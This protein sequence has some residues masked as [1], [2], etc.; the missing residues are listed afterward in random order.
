MDVRLRRP[1]GPVGVSELDVVVARDMSVVTVAVV[2]LASQGWTTARPEG[3]SSNHKVTLTHELRDVSSALAYNGETSGSARGN[4]EPS[5]VCKNRDLSMCHRRAQRGCDGPTV[6]RC[7]TLIK[8]N[9]TQTTHG[10]ID[11]TV[12][13][14]ILRMTVSTSPPVRFR[15]KLTN[16]DSMTVSHR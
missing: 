1:P 7:T 8:T 4:N 9:T 12:M 3:Q 14:M 16:T 10:T 15:H 2:E 13:R 5:G 6:P 11:S